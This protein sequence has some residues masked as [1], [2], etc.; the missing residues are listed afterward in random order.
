VSQE[1]AK[2]DDKITPELNRIARQLESPRPL[3]AAVGKELE[4]Q[5]R[6]HFTK[7]DQQGNAQ[8]F[9]RRHFWARVVRAATALTE[10]LDRR[11]T[12][13]IASPEFLHKLTGG[14]VTPK[15]AKALSIPLS[16]EA[17]KAGS[18][19]LYPKP[20]TMVVRRGH[21]PLLVETGTIGKSK[22]W[23]IAYVL[24]KSVTH[25]ADPNALPNMRDVTQALIARGR[26]VLA[27]AMRPGGRA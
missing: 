19:S 10:V 22:S 18:A 26:A 15:R 23:K 9:P 14:K 2:W 13:T 27:R 25:P 4:V 16:A 1:I 6:G 17:Y 24:L 20:L 8:G 7:R 11:A 12:V 3:M 21:A 5:L